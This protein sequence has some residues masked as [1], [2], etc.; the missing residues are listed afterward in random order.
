MNIKYGKTLE[1]YD[2]DEKRVFGVVQGTTKS[3]EILLK[4]WG[5]KR[6]AY[7]TKDKLVNKSA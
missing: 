3:G 6:L 7:I 5:R 2:K 4:V 1:F